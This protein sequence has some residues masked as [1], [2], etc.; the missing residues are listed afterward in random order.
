MLCSF[1]VFI[2]VFFVVFV[3]VFFLFVGHCVSPQQHVFD[4]VNG[5]HS[6]VSRVP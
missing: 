5:I 6:G 2:V 1:V 3:V 4:A